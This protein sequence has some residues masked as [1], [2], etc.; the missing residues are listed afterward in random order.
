MLGTW[1]VK[2]YQPNSDVFQQFHHGVISPVAP[3]ASLAEIISYI[4]VNDP[5]REIV[6]VQRLKRRIGTTWEDSATL[7]ITFKG[8]AKAD[9][10]TIGKSFYR[11][12]PYVSEP[13][14]CYNCQRLGPLWNFSSRNRVT[15]VSIQDGV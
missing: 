5:K 12:R 10:V 6:N 7:K 2:C 1:A 9:S 8:T 3:N 14:Q 4:S 11:V 13:M 15:P